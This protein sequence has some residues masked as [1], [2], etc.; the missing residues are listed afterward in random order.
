MSSLDFQKLL[1]LYCQEQASN[2]PYEFIPYKFGAFSFTSYSDR[3]KLIERGLLVDDEHCW[4]L[5]DAARR[6]LGEAPDARLTA[7]AQHHDGLRGDELVA[8]TYKR[9]PYFATR[10]EIAERVLKDDRDA[11]ARITA[12]RAARP[13]AA[14]HTIGYEGHSLESYLN[15]L[16]RCGVSMLCD[17]R[18][19]PMSRKYGFSKSTLA[20]ACEGVGIRYEHLPELG[21]ASEQRQ[22]LETQADFDALFREY[23]RTWLPTQGDALMKI[24]AWVEAGEHVALT[25]YEHLPHQCHR[26]CV[27]DALKA[28]YGK[29]MN[30]KHL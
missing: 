10:S 12:L 27:A 14:L 7:F 2:A 1:F 4:K 9:F 25:C 23:E 6:L 20:R 29:D 15:L 22:G 21:I 8:S 16:L 5:T 30:P 24:R 19:N 26:H 3:R 17:V 11:L 18:R 28:R 13:E